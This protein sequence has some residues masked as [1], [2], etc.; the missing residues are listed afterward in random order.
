M[1]TS[2]SFYGCENFLDCVIGRR[3]F[4]YDKSFP[5]A[6]QNEYYYVDVRA[7]IENEPRDNDYDYYFDIYD[8]LPEGLV[9]YEHHRTLTIEGTP[10]E[11][12]T[13]HITVHLF[14]EG[15]EFVNYTGDGVFY[16]D[17]YLCSNTTAKTYTLVIN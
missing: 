13:F 5:S 7:E 12:G 1:I 3:P 8:E 10:Q 11:S 4:L 6:V 15:P 17:D 2:M 16:E 14:V 9:Y